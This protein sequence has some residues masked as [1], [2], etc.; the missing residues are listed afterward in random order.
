MREHQ[1]HED[2][3]Q[4]LRRIGGERQWAVAFGHGANL[5][6]PTDRQ[7]QFIMRAASRLGVTG[8]TETCLRVAIVLAA[9]LFRMIPALS[10]SY[11]I[12]D[13]LI[14][15]SVFLLSTSKVAKEWGLWLFA[16][17][18]AEDYTYS[19]PEW[20]AARCSTSHP[21][22]GD[23]SMS[24][25]WIRTA[26]EAGLWPDHDAAKALSSE[27]GRLESYDK[28]CKRGF[29]ISYSQKRE[30]NQWQWYPTLK[31][32]V[33]TM[34]SEGNAV[35]MDRMAAVQNPSQSGNWAVYGSLPYLNCKVLLHPPTLGEIR[36]KNCLF[37]GCP[38]LSGAD[39]ERFYLW[40]RSRQLI[41]KLRIIQRCG[42][43]PAALLVVYDRTAGGLL[44]D[45]ASLLRGWPS[46]ER[47]VARRRHGVFIRPYSDIMIA[48][49]IATVKIIQR[50]SIDLLGDLDY[51]DVNELRFLAK[52]L[53][54]EFQAIRASKDG[55]ISLTSMIA[56][57][58]GS[59]F[60]FG[61]HE[62]FVQSSATGPEGDFTGFVDDDGY[63]MAEMEF[64]ADKLRTLVGVSGILSGQISDS[65][66]SEAT[67]LI[68][69]AC[70]DKHVGGEKIRRFLSALQRDSIV[71]KVTAASQGLLRRPNA[72]CTLI[73][74][75]AA[76]R[77]DNAVP[78]GDDFTKSLH[79]L[80]TRGWFSVGEVEANTS[81]AQ[82]PGHF[83]SF[84]T[85]LSLSWF[86]SG[87]V[88]TGSARRVWLDEVEGIKVVYITARKDV[89]GMIEV[90]FHREERNAQVQHITTIFQ[91]NPEETDLARRLMDHYINVIPFS[92]AAKWERRGPGLGIVSLK[93]LICCGL[94]EET[95][96]AFDQR[97]RLNLNPRGS[98]APE[99]TPGHFTS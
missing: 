84:Q 80:N 50:L 3:N 93:N 2:L 9:A 63:A 78:Y 72:C 32:V 96:R 16:R 68:V 60:T 6:V 12:I 92:V 90:V 49:V 83:C 97:P 54:L 55:G 18:A 61:L 76:F 31:E 99:E 21:K 33:D 19:N 1:K 75:L 42:D 88:E 66:V 41:A 70:W 59:V 25:L 73:P 65:H 67:R 40:L 57:E 4:R 58:A 43:I 39:V 82:T 47:R 44:A 94:L 46:L 29:A 98:H 35:W 91:F 86:G 48:R 52:Q 53:T 27:D 62:Q 77:I 5:A 34:A 87:K 71:V 14:L 95:A 28:P 30:A 10:G 15:S 17:R 69:E 51:G 79:S 7:V 64:P 13:F 56:A 74:S 11:P 24:E 26:T 37:R 20:I 45:V 8:L 85:K 38:N 89:T 23:N 36:P 22:F 81:I